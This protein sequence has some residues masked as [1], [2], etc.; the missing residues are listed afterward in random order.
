M[1][2]NS[3][4]PRPIDR[5]TAELD[6]AEHH[7]RPYGRTKAKLDHRLAAGAPRSGGR[8]VLVTAINPTPAGEG[9]TV[10]T[11]G[12]AMA[13][14]RLGQR[15]IATLRQPSMGPVFGV[16]GGGAGGGRAAVVPTDEVNF[17]LTGDMH[18]VGQAHNLLAAATDTSL[19]LKNPLGL[20]PERITWR[21]VVDVNDRALREIRIGLGGKKNG[22][23]RET[24]FDITS[25]SEVMAILAMAGDLADLRARL[26][27]IQVG[28]NRDGE[29]VTAEELEVAGAMA[30]VLRDAID[31]TLVQTSEGTPVLVH[32]G[33]FANIAQGNCSVIACRTAATLADYVVTEAGFGADMGAEKF[34]DLKCRESGMRPDAVVIV[35]SA[36]A[37]RFHSGVFKVKPGRKLPSGLFEPNVELVERG[38]ANLGGHLDLVATFGVPAVVC[39]NRFPG[40]SPEELAAIERFALAHGARAVAV[41]D[42]FARGSEGG[43]E[44]AG[45][46]RA[47]C[48]GERREPNLLYEL[49]QPLADK[50]ERVATRAYGAAGVSYSPE[51]RAA[52]ERAEASGLGRLG[53]CIAKTQYSLSHDPA[54]L[55]RPTGFEFPVRELRVLA[56]AGFCVPIAGAMS[57]MPGMGSRPAYR[58]IDVDPDGR[59]VGLT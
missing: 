54:L 20:D 27:R 29:P 19:L 17:H 52:L 38:L 37:L 47:V 9:K 24:G 3:P 30:A 32:A 39:V 53:V 2:S 50:I 16:K 22:I 59:I 28:V 55:G 56:G 44:L 4:V 14:E 41:S 15:A 51:A 35:A 36:K 13:L 1:A 18:A 58:G 8:Y 57:T 10:T 40:D 34:F 33:P 21:R 49:D 31:P 25:S 11:I 26:G 5:L 46:V 43:V 23:P 7:W 48:E 6:L 12:L 45:A 42:V